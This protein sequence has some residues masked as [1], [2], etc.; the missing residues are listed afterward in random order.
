MITGAK[1]KNKPKRK[2]TEDIKEPQINFRDGKHNRW[3]Y[4]WIEITRL[5]TEENTSELEDT[6]T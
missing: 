6:A 4:Y 5:D 2:E 3:K 1:K